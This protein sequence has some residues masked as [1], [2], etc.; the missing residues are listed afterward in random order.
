MDDHHDFS[1]PMRFRLKN[2][3]YIGLPIMFLSLGELWP[4]VVQRQ[5][6]TNISSASGSKGTNGNGAIG[7]GGT[8]RGG[9]ARASI[10]TRGPLSTFNLVVEFLHE[11]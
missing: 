9:G 3:D 8:T 4:Q 1:V 5:L 6:L 11:L 7:S 10:S 2:G